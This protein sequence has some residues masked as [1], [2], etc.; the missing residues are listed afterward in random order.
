MSENLSL[1]DYKK[2]KIYP[3]SQKI[4]KDQNHL[5]IICPLQKGHYI[6]T[7]SSFHVFC[8][9]KNKATSSQ[10]NMIFLLGHRHLFLV[11]L[12]CTIEF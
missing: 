1:V 3:M 11:G 6:Y 9:M 4:K 5:E 2:K 8:F 12:I 7:Y 10:R